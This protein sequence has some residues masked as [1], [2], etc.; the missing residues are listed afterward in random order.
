MAAAE[1]GV[2]D[3]QLELARLYAHGVGGAR[4]EAA[5]ARWERAAAEA[6]SADGCLR[7]AERRGGAAG[8]VALAIPWF[9]RAAEA[10]SAAAAA[11][12]AHLYLMG[13]E[14]PYDPVA[15]ERWM[16][17]ARALGWNWEPGNS[18]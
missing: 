2:A 9:E 8:G 5:A 7:V 11:R 14:V 10:G 17:R 16:A 15:A 12:L 13:A 18:A 1:A 4:D 3:A 6:G